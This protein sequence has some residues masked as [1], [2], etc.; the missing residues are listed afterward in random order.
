MISWKSLGMVGSLACAACLLSPDS[1]AQSEDPLIA[2]L[3]ELT[4]APAPPGFEGPVRQIMAERMRPYA[5]QISYDGLGSVVG[6]QG[7]A[8]PH[9]ML[10]A[11]MD[12]LGGMVRR[13]RPD[14]YISMQMLGYWLDQALPDQRW[15]VLGRKGPLTAVTPIQDAHIAHELH[16]R[17]I[18]ADDI[19]LDVVRAMLPRWN[20]SG[21]R[22]VILWPR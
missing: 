15:V 7:K 17:V 6:Q 9:I 8:G 5:D 16:G 10:D 11:H 3:K 14:G 1:P 21:S 12:E 2:L 18:P 4:D 20:N 19:Y 22:R 13:I